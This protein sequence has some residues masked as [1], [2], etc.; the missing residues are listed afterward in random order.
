MSD[1]PTGDWTW[2]NDAADRF[3]RAWHTSPRP[4]IEDYLAGAEPGLRDALLEE[5]VCVEIE[6]RR[7]AGEEPTAEAYRQRFPE[8]AAVVEAVFAPAASAS[9]EAGLST[10]LN[11]GTPDTDPAHEPGTRVRYFGDYELIRELGRGGMG[12]VYRARQISLNRLVALKMIRSAVLA[13]GDELRRFQNEAEAVAA[14]DHPHIVPILEVGCNDGQRYFSMK[15]IGGPSLDKKLDDYASDPRTAARLV[16]TAAEA[17]HHAHQRGILHRD[18]KPS[19]IVIDDRGEPFVTD[20]G[21]AKRV[22]GDSE[23][24]HTGA[25]LGTP[26]YMAPE[27]A[28]GRRGAVTTASDVYGLGAILYALLS[29]R[30]PFGGDSAGETLAQVRESLPTPPSRLKPQVP[31][32]LEVICLKCLEKEPRSRYGSAQSLADDLDNWLRG[33]PIS[34][35]PVPSWERAIKWARRRPEISA[36]LLTLT[37]VTSVGLSGVIWEWREAVA[38]AESERLTTYVARVNLAEKELQEGHVDRANE[39]LD[40]ERPRSGLRDLRGFEWF[41]L[42]HVC[43]SYL[44]K[45]D[46]RFGFAPCVAFSPDSRFVAWSDQGRVARIWDAGLTREI[47][48]IDVDAS[49]VG[50]LAYNPSGSR[51]AAAGASRSKPKVAW[52]GLIDVA[53]GRVERSSEIPGFCVDVKFSPDGKLYATRDQRGMVRI[54][55]VASGENLRSLQGG[56]CS[57]TRLAFNPDGRRI[58]SAGT[59]HKT[60]SVWDVES[61]RLEKTLTG[62]AGIVSG[63]AFAPGGGVLAC[64]A[65]MTD[66]GPSEIIIWDLSRGQA[67]MN[68]RGHTGDI[69]DLKFSPDGRELISAGG[70]GQ[71]KRWDA[72]SGKELETIRAH[73]TEVNSVAFS[74]DGLRFASAG[75]RMN[76]SGEVKLWDREGQRRDPHFTGH[77]AAFS[78]MGNRIAIARAGGIDV[79]DLGSLEVVEVLGSSE[80]S[81]RGKHFVDV[82]VAPAGDWVA[83]V[84]QAGIINIWE[85]GS[86]RLARSITGDPPPNV[87]IRLN[88]RDL[89]CSPDGRYL[90]LTGMGKTALWE[91]PDFRKVWERN[92]TASR[93]ARLAFCSDG[94]HVATMTDAETLTVLDASTGRDSLAIQARP[95]GGV[96]CLAFSSD[97]RLIATGEY[98]GRLTLYDAYSG[99]V[100]RKF[101]GHPS[102]VRDLTFSPDSRRLVSAGFREVIK[103]WDLETG[104]ELISIKEYADRVEFSPNGK[105]LVSSST[106]GVKLRSTR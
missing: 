99:K 33:L 30:A 70:E 87:G 72:R 5:L 3:E 51:L 11:D 55:D 83:A 49:F 17:V 45:G 62:H 2:I 64:A 85:T 15:L 53:T 94:R 77:A 103:F 74:P 91:A 73:Q 20:F 66:G 75:G 106:D 43:H 60:V 104:K 92:S 93:P 8:H 80:E 14:L 37:V 68:L 27:Q 23:L 22:E 98:R 9:P 102:E 7:G 42:D 26:A 56:G 4:R 88:D 52:I 38:S 18:L 16:M 39:I 86:G 81:T 25:I 67:R 29:G 61:G 95:E 90:A 89:A 28:S 96:L 47:R 79:R 40:E 6:L 59:E 19:N 58:A 84:D 44:A 101:T 54:W 76:V 57:R 31:R 34:A 105:H 36:L 35:R 97:H 78:R 82:A 69:N 32:D 46:S 71:I 21:L 10:A 13:G 1:N 24:T 41:Y 12:V 100:L 48:S 65:N 50:A 63:V